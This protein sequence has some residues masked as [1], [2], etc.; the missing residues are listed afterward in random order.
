MII[1]NST[2][3]L[4]YK[5]YESYIDKKRRGKTPNHYIPTPYFAAVVDTMAGYMF[6]NVKYEPKTETDQGFAESLNDILADN[7]ADIK[8]MQTG[9]YALTYNSGVELVYTDEASNIK[10]AT[11]DS[12]D[13]I[14]VY[15]DDIEPS[16][17]CGIWM[18]KSLDPDY[19]HY[20]DVFYA[21]EWQK[22]KY[23]SSGAVIV[24]REP[25]TAL[26]FDECPVVEYKANIVSN[27]SP[28]HCVLHYVSALD[29]VISGNS[30]EIDRLTDALLI[31]SQKFTDEELDHMEEIR[32][33]MGLEKED[34]AEY[35]QKDT[36]PEFRRYVTEFLVN[37]IHKHSHVIDWY[38]PD[39]GLSGQ[40]SAKALRTR[41]FDMD[42]YS[43]QIEKQ[44]REGAEKRVRLISQLMSPQRLPDGEVNIIYNRTMPS[45][46]LDIVQALSNVDFISKQ[47]KYEILGIDAEEEAARLDEEREKTMSM[48]ALP[49]PESED[50]E[51]EQEETN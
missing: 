5:I 34:R 26:I 15:T 22:L 30:N 12:V 32:A 50:E 3:K 49:G 23:N 16:V 36:S 29:A 28:F 4:T 18:Q 1:T 25:S 19:T 27:Q 41:L 38:A 42:M 11:F 45:E 6:Q 51:D 21:D 10:F 44:Y 35:I 48:F 37:E 43:Q 20:L 39:S 17:F 14:I 24:E 40:V 2:E 7:N 46:L 47:T 33:I 8:D 31:M 9:T 13:W